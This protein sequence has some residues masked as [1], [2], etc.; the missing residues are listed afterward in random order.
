LDLFIEISDAVQHAHR[1]GIIHRDLKPTNILVSQSDMA[2]VPKVI[3]F[4]VAKATTQPLTD[5]TLFTHFSQIIGTPLYMSP[6]QADLGNQDIDTRSDVYSL[7]VVLYELLA[8][9]TPFDADRRARGRQPRQ[10]P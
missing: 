10:W 6:E 5:R 3:D 1:K 2:A 7:G 4:G 8:G 9:T